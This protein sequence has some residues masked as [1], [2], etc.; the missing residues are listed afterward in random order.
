MAAVMGAFVGG[1]AS[2]AST[3]VGERSR[4]RRDL[5]QR[6]VDKR[7]HAYSDFI[8]RASKVFVASATHNIDDDDGEIEGMVDLYAISSRIRLFASD[9]VIKEAE[10]VI[11]RI[12]AQYGDANMSTEQLLTNAVEK[13]DDFLKP[14]SIVCRRELRGIQRATPVHW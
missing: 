8:E 14:F 2:L 6:E 10:Q 13:R 1:L 11:D 5:L 7:E 3:W 12:F 9:Q 4:H